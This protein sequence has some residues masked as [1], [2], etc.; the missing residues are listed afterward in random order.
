MKA[1]IQL[2]SKQHRLILLL[3]GIALLIL[4]FVI[5]QPT[6]FA[7][8]NKYNTKSHVAQLL[9]DTIKNKTINPQI[10]WM[11]R[12]FSSPGNFFFERDGINTLKA[13]KTLQ[14]LGVNM[15]VNSLY[16][17]LIFSSPTWNSIEFLTKGIMLTDIV[18]ETMSSC[19][20]MMFEQKNEFICKRQDGIVLVVFLKPFNEMKQANAF[21]DVAGRD[22]KIVEGKNWLVV[23]TVQM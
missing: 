16:P 4:I 12:E 13:Q 11:A 9:N 14:T 19:Q 8:V 20:E 5:F 15:N 23:S 18:P 1:I 7:L 17:F 21:F 3:Y 6:A 22:G 2:Y 10:F